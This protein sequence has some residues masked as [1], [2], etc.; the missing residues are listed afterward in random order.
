[1]KITDYLGEKEIVSIATNKTIPK[2][3]DIEWRLTW[4][5]NAKCKMCSIWKFKSKNEF[6]TNLI[7]KKIRELKKIGTRKILFS[8]GEPLVRKDLPKIIAYCSKQG[9]ISEMNTNGLLLSS[10]MCRLLVTAG[11]KKVNVSLDAPNEIHDE[12]R[13]VKGLFKKVI[14]G[15][16]NLRKI[17]KKKQIWININTVIMKQNYN[18]ILKF[19]KLKEIVDFDSINFIPV[20]INTA[21]VKKLKKG[22]DSYWKEVAENMSDCVLSKKEEKRAKELIKKFKNKANLIL[23]NEKEALIKPLKRCFAIFF[24]TVIQPSGDVVPCCY[25]SK[26]ESVLG[27]IINQDFKSVWLGE[28]YVKFRDSLKNNNPSCVKCFRYSNLNKFVEELILDAET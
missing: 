18:S 10:R 2:P 26:K 7:K 12:I 16:K 24:H 1:L 20:K 15:L 28:K 11:L 13:N 6:S 27:N 19:L 9:I 4:K 22:N 8:G 14:L 17:D 3:I 23:V 21:W 25:F 5:C